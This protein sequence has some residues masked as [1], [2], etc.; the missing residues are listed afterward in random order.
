MKFQINF[1]SKNLDEAVWDRMLDISY[2]GI[3]IDRA[4]ND[5]SIPM[6]WDASFEIADDVLIISGGVSSNGFGDCEVKIPLDEAKHFY[7]IDIEPRDKSVAQEIVQIFT[8][9][10]YTIK[11]EQA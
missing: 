3:C 9:H 4:V 8:E 6:P 10:N 11:K 2:N 7:H 5:G 1:N